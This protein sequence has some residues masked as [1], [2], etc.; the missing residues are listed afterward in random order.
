MECVIFDSSI[1]SISIIPKNAIVNTKKY[2]FSKKMLYLQQ[3]LLYNA[4]IVTYKLH[5]NGGDEDAYFE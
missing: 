4:I 3:K 2:I 5:L 1:I